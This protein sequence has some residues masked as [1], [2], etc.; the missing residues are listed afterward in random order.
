V[1]TYERDRQRRRKPVHIYGPCL[2]ALLSLT[3]ARTATT[4]P[5]SNGGTLCVGREKLYAPK[6]VAMHCEAVSCITGL[7][8]G[9]GSADKAWEEAESWM[10]AHVRA[11]DG[12][13]GERNGTENLVRTM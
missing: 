10:P 6:V 1:T 4:S 5:R 8:W 7:N 13:P 9:E 3:G 2:T 11:R 12:M